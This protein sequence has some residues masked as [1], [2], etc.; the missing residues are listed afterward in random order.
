MPFL[1]DENSPRRLLRGWVHAFASF[2]IIVLTRIFTAHFQ[3]WKYNS[4]LLRVQHAFCHLYLTTY[5]EDRFLFFY[6]T[7]PLLFIQH[8][9]QTQLAIIKIHHKDIM[10]DCALYDGYVLTFFLAQQMAPRWKETL[11]GKLMRLGQTSSSPLPRMPLLRTT[12]LGNGKVSSTEFHH[13][14]H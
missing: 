3:L 10:F 2:P 11:Q 1:K 6:C 13:C 8:Q 4:H 9:G 12:V 14:L 7:Y 5:K